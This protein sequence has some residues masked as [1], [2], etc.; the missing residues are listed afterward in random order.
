M[1][2][3]MQNNRYEKMYQDLMGHMEALHARNRLRVKVGII[4][5]ALLPFI[6]CFIRWVTDSDKVVFLLVWVFCLFVVCGYLLGVGYLDDKVKKVI[7]EEQSQAEEIS[8][9][10]EGD[11]E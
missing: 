3:R 10:E 4:V 1:D 6:L 5:L 9:Q 11:A 2:D 8:G 7:S